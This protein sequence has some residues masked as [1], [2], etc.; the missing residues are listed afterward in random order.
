MA[1][2]TKATDAER[3][4]WKSMAFISITKQFFA[5][6][7]V[8]IVIKSVWDSLKSGMGLTWEI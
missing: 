6:L 7:C 5:I 4:E 2:K 3:S 8:M 1:P